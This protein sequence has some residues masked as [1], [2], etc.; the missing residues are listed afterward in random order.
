MQKLGPKVCKRYL[1]GAIWTQGMAL[2]LPALALTVARGGSSRNLGLA[3]YLRTTSCIR[4]YRFRPLA[5][6]LAVEAL[7]SSYHN[8]ET[9]L[10]TIYPYYGK[11]IEG[12]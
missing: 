3:E 4:G 2:A 12:P 10:F 8:P 7:K 5:Y 9:K 1:L 11:V 6:W